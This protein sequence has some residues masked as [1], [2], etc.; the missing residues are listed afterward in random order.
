MLKT[1][2]YALP[3]SLSLFSVAIANESS[4]RELLKIN[5]S[6]NFEQRYGVEHSLLE[7]MGY[8]YMGDVDLHETMKQTDS[9]VGFGF[10]RFNW[11]M[12]ESELGI[13]VSD[14]ETSLC[15]NYEVKAWWL[16]EKLGYNGNNTKEVLRRYYYGDTERERYFAVEAVARYYDGEL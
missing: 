16:S 7:A 6:V 15:E 13:T 10:H 14:S 8:A 12:I 2:F 5:C 4:N 1:I 11:E 9:S 3:L